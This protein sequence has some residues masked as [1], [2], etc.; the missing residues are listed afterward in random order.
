MRHFKTLIKKECIE[1]ISS[2]RGAALYLAGC[3]VLSVFSLLL[4]SNTELS[5]L[6]NAQAVYMMSA[7]IIALALLIAVIR[8]SD[9]FAGER[10]RETLE[11]LLITPVSPAE[12]AIAK[13]MGLIFSWF[14][15]FVLSIPYLWAVGSTGQNLIPALEYLFISGTLLVVIFGGF[16][17][18]LSARM[19]TFKG[20]LSIGLTAFL[21]SG[22]PILLG[23][24]L[25]QSTVGRFID[26]I[27]PFANALNM[28]DSVV[29][30]SLGVLF[31]IIPLA[32]LIFYTIAAIWVLSMTTR[33]VEL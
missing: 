23:P 28:L 7:I 12:V 2:S 29:V 4:V 25:R 32:I 14:V 31:Q 33:R 9:G 3:G 5:L 16:S 20:A 10:E 18:A 24:S 26:L 27:N 21:L 11:L 8:G 30:D 19:K 6:D 22:S 17:L 1:E 15:V 13:L